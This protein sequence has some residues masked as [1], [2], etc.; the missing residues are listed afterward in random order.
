MPALPGPG[1]LD[2]GI[3]GQQVGLLGNR[4][5]DLDQRRQRAH[6]VGQP[7]NALEVVPELL[8]LRLQLHIDGG[9]DLLIAFDPEL[10][11]FR[12]I[13]AALDGTGDVFSLLAGLG[14]EDADLLDDLDDL[15]LGFGQRIADLIVHHVDVGLGGFQFVSHR[16]AARGDILQ[17]GFA[18]SSNDSQF[19]NAAG[20]PGPSSSIDRS[21][22]EE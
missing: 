16:R 20:G 4:S 14:I 8:D 17:I 2:L 3:Q 5:D 9:N 10:G 21:A 13:L 1:R 11:A 12:Q 6:L 19:G 18:Q 15:A 22:R 7:L